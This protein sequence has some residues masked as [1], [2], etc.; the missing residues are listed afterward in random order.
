KFILD[1]LPVMGSE[2]INFKLAGEL[3]PG[4]ICPKNQKDYLY[5]IMP[6]RTEE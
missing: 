4:I 2:K 5:I 3:S 1:A 6:L